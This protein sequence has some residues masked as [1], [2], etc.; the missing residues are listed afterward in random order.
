MKAETNY[1]FVKEKFEGTSILMN[2]SF[3]FQMTFLTIN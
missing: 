2:M 1:T 3:S